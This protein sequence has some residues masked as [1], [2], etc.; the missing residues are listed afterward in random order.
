[1][2]GGHALSR[3]AEEMRQGAKPLLFLKVIAMRWFRIVFVLL[4]A[5]VGAGVYLYASGQ[6][7]SS[8]QNWL[9]KMRGKSTATFRT[10]AVVRDN[11]L[12]TISATGTVEPEEVIDVGAQVAG[13]IEKFGTDPR[14]DDKPLEKRRSIDYGTPVKRGTILALIDPSLYQSRVDQCSANLNRSKTN[15]VQ[16]EAKLFQAEREWKRDKDLVAP[17]IVTQSDADVAEAAYRTA[18]ANV[19]DAKAAIVQAEA[20][21]KEA[22]TNLGYTKISSPVDG[23]ILDRR[24]NIGQTVVASLNAPSLFL[25]AKDLRKMQVW[26]SVNEA[27]IGTIHPGQKVK[28]TVDAFPGQIFV[29]EVAQDQPRLNA[30]MTQNVVTYT[31]VINTD[32]SSGKL[33]PYLTANLSFEVNRRNS[34]LLVPNA[35][36]RWKPQPSQMVP[37]ARDAAATGQRR[38]PTGG[39]DKG[40]GSENEAQDQ[41]VVWVEDNGLARP[42]KV[43]TGVTDGLVTEIVEGDLK[44]GMELIVGEARQGNGDS[45]GNNNPFAPKMFGGQQRK[46]QQ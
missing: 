16:M 37:E 3:A 11:L 8:V 9:D 32:N 34:V 36:L 15:L 35:A 4:L 23:V 26:S 29:G 25:I 41:G 21:L 44:E 42:I 22:E 43:R 31:V 28:F 40:A 33:L 13:M 2:V 12:V 45:G 17:R 38:K 20:T 5:L 39:K 18:E 19:A 10:S 6:V 30:S 7:P 1:M 24:V 46:P 14:D 27:D